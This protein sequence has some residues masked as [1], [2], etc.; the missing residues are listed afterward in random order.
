M[1]E[2][3]RYRN[4]ERWNRDADW[5]RGRS[6][7]SSDDDSRRRFSEDDQFGRSTSDFGRSSPSRGDFGRGN[8]GRG[9]FDTDFERNRNLGSGYTGSPNDH[10]RG[11]D[12]S[13]R[14]RPISQDQRGT[15]GGLGYGG[16]SSGESSGEG[17]SHGYDSYGR[18]QYG[19]SYG[20]HSP[21]EGHWRSQGRSDLKRDPGQDD[22]GFIER[23]A[24]TVSS[25][26]EGDEQPSH[27]G[28]GPKGYARSDDRIRE[29]VSDRLG[30]DWMVDAREVEVTVMSGEVTLVGT[31]TSRDQRR[32]AEDVA[33]SVS[34]VKHIQ[35]NLRIIA[36]SGA[37]NVGTASS[38]SDTSGSDT[39][40]SESSSGSTRKG[41]T[42][43]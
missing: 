36:S 42:S 29:D 10:G 18:D 7:D 30:D 12:R 8:F 28:R 22:R 5:G 23:A 2:R 38:G 19:R 24:D 14:D 3:D 26:F 11:Y 31:V 15:Y 6:S 39:S 17:R 32:R 35:N 21:Y 43:G 27:R 34:G 33:E 16:S 4:D 1:A 25:W 9:D 40:R 41:G 13:T 37:G 20:A